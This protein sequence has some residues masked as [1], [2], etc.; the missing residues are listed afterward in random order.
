MIVDILRGSRN[1]KIIASRM[2]K[3]STYGLMKSVPENKIRDIINSLVLTG[4]LEI[5]NSEYPVVKVTKSGSEVL[6]NNCSIRM[7]VQKDYRDNEKSAKSKPRVMNS[8]INEELFE[9]LRQ[10]RNKLATKQGVPAYIVFSDA[11]LRH[12]CTLMPSD[13]D[14]FLEVN[15]V[16]QAKLEKY[17]SVFLS[18]IKAYNKG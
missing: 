11:T 12:M 15:G 4:R 6:Q 13:E 1:Q 17:G 9:R 3:I 14:E 5:T 8:S 10:L 7:K 16:G 18:E 2:D